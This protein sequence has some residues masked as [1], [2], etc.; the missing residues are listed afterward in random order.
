MSTFE[1]DQLIHQPVRTKILMYLLSQGESDFSTIKKS[2]ELSDGHM[3]NHMKQLVACGYVEMKK[4]F[5]FNKPRTNYKVSLVGKNKFEEYIS[6]LKKM[7]QINELG[8]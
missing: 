2:L 4:E 7:I 1:F 5:V 3:S 6:E 8:L